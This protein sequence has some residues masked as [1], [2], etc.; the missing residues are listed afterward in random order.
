ML[1]MLY[2]CNAF[3]SPVNE[4]YYYYFKAQI[5]YYYFNYYYFKGFRLYISV[6]LLLF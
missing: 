6:I 4:L 5:Y 3:F 1:K 2:S